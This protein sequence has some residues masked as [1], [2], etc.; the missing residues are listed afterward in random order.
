MRT[1]LYILVSWLVVTGC[2]SSGK[3]EELKAKYDAAQA[4]LAGE[5]SKRAGLEQSLTEQQAAAAEQ[6]RVATAKAA[7][8]EAQ[9][10][11]L[12]RQRG[13]HAQQVADAI[14]ENER[15]S[16]ELAGLIKDR[17]RL[18][19]S[20]ARLQQAIAALAHRKAEADR[21][22]AEFRALLERFKGL[23]DAGQLRVQILD[24]R[25][26]L[27]LPSDVLFDSGSARLSKSGKD[28]LTS[29]AQVLAT[30]PDRRFQVEGH[31][32]NVPISN[33]QYASNWELASARA[34]IVV[35]TMVDA[36][37]PNQALSAASYGE[38]HPVT[39]NA[40]DIDRKVNRRIEIVI[41]PDL[42]SLPGFEE[43]NEAV[44]APRS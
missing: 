28:A 21:R 4:S 20:T 33:A 5:Q 42:S 19:D 1:A 43:L 39:D 13:E 22:V 17:S 7:D 9:I 35:K 12:T 8:Y 18:K 31:T 10:A 26:V 41:V 2:V 37:M 15:L 34:L 29:V 11:L 6:Q 27:T 44:A 25:M 40:T 36:G 30:M 3:H 14:K 23:I 32:D 24:G 38:F 16:A